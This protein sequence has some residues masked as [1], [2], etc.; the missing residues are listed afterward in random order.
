MSAYRRRDRQAS[1]LCASATT[2]IE[3]NVTA[4][5]IKLVFFI[6]FRPIFFLLAN[7]FRIQFA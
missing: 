1:L 6:A 7:A 4:T 5:G 3:S 2:L